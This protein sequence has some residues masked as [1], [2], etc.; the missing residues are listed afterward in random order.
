MINRANCNLELSN[1]TNSLSRKGLL[2]IANSIFKEQQSVSTQK[3]YA[4]NSN[5]SPSRDKIRVPIYYFSDSAA[6][7]SSFWVRDYLNRTDCQLGFVFQS[8]RPP[9]GRT[10]YQSEFKEEF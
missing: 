10:N 1:P 6:Q 8:S 7:V 5:F 2:L 3:S 9:E 4:Q